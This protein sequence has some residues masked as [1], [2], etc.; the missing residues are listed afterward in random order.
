MWEK[1]LEQAIKRQFRVGQQLFPLVLQLLKVISI[2]RVCKTEK[3]SVLAS[4]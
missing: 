2:N 3:K 4:L 1:P